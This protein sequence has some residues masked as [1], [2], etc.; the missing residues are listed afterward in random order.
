MQTLVPLVECNLGYLDS[1]VLVVLMDGNPVSLS[2][3]DASNGNSRLGRLNDDSLWYNN[4]RGRS[5]SGL[6]KLGS[7]GVQR[8]DLKAV[9]RAVSPT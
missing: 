9:I 6:A 3:D 1:R 8:L 7:K 2:I 4:C 5:S